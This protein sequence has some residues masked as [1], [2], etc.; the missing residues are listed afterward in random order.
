LLSRKYKIPRRIPPYI[1]MNILEEND[2]VIVVL[3][4]LDYLSKLEEKPSPY[5]YAAYSISKLK[6]PLSKMKG[7]LRSIKGVGKVTE[8]IIRE[9]LLTGSSSYYE[10]LLR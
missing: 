6:E 5:G 4:H 8:S 9:I 1:Y 2:L 3:E 7:S 10:K